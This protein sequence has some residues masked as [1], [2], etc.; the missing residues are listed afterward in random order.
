MFSRSNVRPSF[1]QKHCF[2]LALKSGEFVLVLDSQCC[3]N[4]N[5]AD[6]T[7]GRDTKGARGCAGRAGCT[8]NASAHT[9]SL[10][11]WSRRSAALVARA[12]RVLLRMPKT[13]TRA[14]LKAAP[15]AASRAM[16]A[17]ALH[18]IVP[19]AQAALRSHPLSCAATPAYSEFHPL[20]ELRDGRC[21]SYCALCGYGTR[22][23]R[24]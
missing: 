5:F 17:H 4:Y 1:Y 24:G 16:T 13:A 6:D 11:A 20:H 9:S 7:R 14:A 15:V 8:T 12:A 19:V 22:T 21:Y 18:A 2:Q 10:D 3:E 23:A